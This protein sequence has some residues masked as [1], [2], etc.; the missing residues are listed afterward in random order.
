MLIFA[1]VL[2]LIQEPAAVLICFC[3]LCIYITYNGL[4]V[5]NSNNMCNKMVF[6][7]HQIVYGMN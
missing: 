6:C 1:Y 2:L 5:L 7:L 4:L 3:M